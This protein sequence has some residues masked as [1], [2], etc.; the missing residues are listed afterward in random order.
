MEDVQTS[1]VTA[2]VFYRMVGL[3][4]RVKLSCNVSA[5][6]A[7]VYIRCTVKTNSFISMA[8]SSVL[9]FPP[10]SWYHILSTC[11]VTN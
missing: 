2:S 1:S 8:V 7:K 10:C 6:S 4:S 11:L 3:R 5:A 9:S